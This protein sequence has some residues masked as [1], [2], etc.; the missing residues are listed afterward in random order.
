VYTD[1]QR[2]PLG[3][4][5]FKYRSRGSYPFLLCLQLTQFTTTWHKLTGSLTEALRQE[6]IIPRSPSPEV[7]LSPVNP[8]SANNGQL[9]REERLARLLLCID[10]LISHVYLHAANA[11]SREKWTKSTRKSKSKTKVT[12]ENANAAQKT[13]LS[14]QERIKL[15]ERVTVL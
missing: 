13:N 15:F 4:M 6:H 10:S 12:T 8:R 7:A 2:N 9:S 11:K 3:I 1:G 5:I 14:P